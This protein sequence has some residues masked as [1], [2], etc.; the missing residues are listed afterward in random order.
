MAQKN[1]STPSSPPRELAN[2]LLHA[3]KTGR[4]ASAFLESYAKQFDRPEATAHPERRRELEAM[5]ER[6][7]LLAMTSHIARSANAAAR[8]ISKRANRALEPVK[9]LRDVIAAIAKESNWTAGDAMEFRGD[10]EIYR[11][12]SAVV[13][14]R[15]SSTRSRIVA[16][17]PFVDRCAILLDPSM[18]E[19]ASRAAAKLLLQLELQ[20]EKLFQEAFS[21]RSTPKKSR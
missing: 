6:E 3:L 2:Q 19:N 7:M 12:L 11:H 5:L 14:A 1:N 10:L 13:A 16:A 9:F 15:A 4:V 18:I 21:K 8:N 20:S 17:G